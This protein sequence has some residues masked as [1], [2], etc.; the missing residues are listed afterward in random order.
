MMADGFL[1]VLLFLGIWIAVFSFIAAVVKERRGRKK[2]V[3]S[4]GHVVSPRDDETCEGKD[5]HIHR[6]LSPQDTADF[7]KRYIVHNDP[8][9]GYVVLNGVKRKISDCKDL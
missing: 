4:D 7:G 6:R 3:S 5:G 8:E 1:F 9:T 2:M